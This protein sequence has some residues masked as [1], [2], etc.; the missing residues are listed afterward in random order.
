[1]REPSE[2]QLR[3]T[4]HDTYMKSELQVFCV[5]K[6]SDDGVLEYV[7]GV[8]DIVHHLRLSKNSHL[9]G[10]WLC[11]NLHVERGSEKPTVVGHSER[12]SLLSLASHVKA[13]KDS[14][15]VLLFKG[16][17]CFHE[18]SDYIK[19]SLKLAS[20]HIRSGFYCC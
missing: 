6:D 11:L 7:T 19:C 3:Q 15:F 20:S 9:S 10:K 5:L 16:Y 18:P 4:S 12:S 8:L 13:T 14:C 1:M 17:F 2:E